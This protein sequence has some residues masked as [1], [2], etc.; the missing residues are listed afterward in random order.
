M[1]TEFHASSTAARFTNSLSAAAQ[2]YVYLCLIGRRY[3]KRSR[4]QSFCNDFDA[5][6]T[7]LLQVATEAAYEAQ[8][9]VV[10]RTCFW[11]DE[12]IRNWELAA[13]F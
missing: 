2:Q 9:Q 4:R 10:E 13:D 1:G 6:R 11:R 12:S 8:K 5:L 3:G 7:E